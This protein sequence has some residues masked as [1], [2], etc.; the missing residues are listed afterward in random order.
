VWAPPLGG[1]R[2]GWLSC[3]GGLP[4]AEAAS[5]LPVPR[6]MTCAE[7]EPQPNSAD[8]VGCHMPNSSIDH[9]ALPEFSSIMQRGQH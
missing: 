8:P 9:A 5:L 6:S 3:P 2:P 7:Y 1:V 4:R